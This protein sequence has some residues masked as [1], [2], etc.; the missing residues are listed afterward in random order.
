MMSKQMNVLIFYIILIIVGGIIGYAKSNDENKVLNTIFGIILGS[1]ISILL[2]KV[3]GEKY[4][5]GEY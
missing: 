5:K 2:W 4:V 1:F 3:Y